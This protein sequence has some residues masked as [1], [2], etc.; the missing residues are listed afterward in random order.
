MADLPPSRL[1]I[2]T[3][4]FYS[5]GMDCFG[6][7]IVKIGRRTE[8]RRGIIFKCMTTS[9]VHLDL[10]E[11]MD[12]DAFLMAFRRFVSRR[13]KPYELLSDNDTNFREETQSYKKHLL[14]WSLTYR[15]K[16]LINKCDL[17]SILPA[18]LILEVFGSEKSGRV[19]FGDQT[20]SEPV[21]RTV[22]VE[23]EGMLNSKPLGY[24]SSDVSDIDPV[25]PNILLMSRHY[26]S[27]PQVV[28]PTEEML[29]RR[30]WR[31]SQ[32]LADHFW[33]RYIKKHFPNLQPPLKW[34][35]EHGDLKAQDV[36]LIVDPQLP[37]AQW[38]L[39]RVSNTF[40]WPDG[41]VR[42]AR[43]R[44]QTKDYVRP[45]SRLFCMPKLAAQDE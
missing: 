21:M 24:I 43:F 13:G 26:P 38:L 31:H 15:R 33:T 28:Y 34:Q 19:S 4:A 27:L 8:K 37:R 14:Q 18:R 3:P 44:V 35:A 30:R 42:T 9:A 2:F 36:V 40:P 7:M 25:T 16:W 1:R 10:V 39:G 20:V 17:R 5:T 11:A 23:V 22:L 6:P 12:T 41:R 32:V 29:G 45:V